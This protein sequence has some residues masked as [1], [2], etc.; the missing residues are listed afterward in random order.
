M[1]AFQTALILVT[2]M[3]QVLSCIRGSQPIFFS[4]CHDH[5]H[6]GGNTDVE[7]GCDPSSCL[8]LLDHQHDHAGDGGV[9]PVEDH[10]CHCHH[11]HI[12]GEAPRVERVRLG[13]TSRKAEPAPAVKLAPATAQVA[14]LL[15][16][17][18]SARSEAPPAAPPQRLL[19]IGS[20]RILV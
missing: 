12:R 11:F 10:R 13:H 19:A 7:P 9:E 18:G 15:R 16:D 4:H 6:D 5:E 8:A 1:K 14:S 2:I 3:G 17:L 20:V